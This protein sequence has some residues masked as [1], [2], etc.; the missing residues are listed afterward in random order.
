ML[1]LAFMLIL[2]ALPFQTIILNE[3]TPCFLNY[4]AGPDMFENCGY[5]DDFLQAALL[6]WMYI[7]GGYFSMFFASVMILFTYIKYHKAV[8]P[9]IIGVAMLPTSY[10][11]FPDQFITFA[12]LLAGALFGILIWYIYI[13]Q[14]KEY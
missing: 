14:T 12:F 11:L 6:P 10:F 2:P 5:G 13:K 3:T 4:T 1:S 8:Y 9:L 7:T